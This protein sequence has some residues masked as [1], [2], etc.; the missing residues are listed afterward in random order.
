MKEVP[1]DVQL[2]DLTLGVVRLASL[3]TNAIA[4]GTDALLAADLSGAQRVIDDD[5]AVDA[6]RHS[7][8]DECLSLLGE[9]GLDADV[10][11]VAA[12][13]RVAHELERSADLM[14]N[15]AK[16]TSR[17]GAHGL[18]SPSRRLVER[19]GR[20]ASVQLR[21]AVNAF[22]DRDCSWASALADMD[23]A[24]DELER[25]LFRHILGASSP[26]EAVVVR[27]VQLALV[28]RH[29]ERIGDHAVTIAEQVHLV[30]TG[31]RAARGRRPLVTAAN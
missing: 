12:T 4:A 16:T 31:T 1:L 28:A 19:M 29:Y 3:T 5:D 2:R 7:I 24:M 22:A 14:V 13:L 15:V 9:G 11:F 26:D 25:S 23:E 20:Q 10:R 18:D 17:L 27:A 8:E 21:V 30:V 6:V